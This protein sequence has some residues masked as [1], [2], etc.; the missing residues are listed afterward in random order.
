MKV[1]IGD[2]G[3]DDAV[4]L[5][6]LAAAS[7]D[8]DL[9]VATAGNVGVSAA[10]TVASRLVQAL[11]TGW[12]VQAARASRLLERPQR[13]G[14]DLKVHGDDGLG[15]EVHRLPP[16]PEPADLDDRALA[17]AEVFACG[18][19]TAVAEA[20]EVGQRP[21]RITWMGGGIEAGN[22]TAHAEFNAWCAPE[23]VDTVLVSRIPLTIVPLD[24]TRQVRL[25]RE[26]LA[27]WHGS[28][29][30]GILAAAYEEMIGRGDAVPHDAV[31]A[32]AWLHPGLFGWQ[33]MTLRCETASGPSYGVLAST[34]APDRLPSLVATECDVIDVTER[35]VA[36]VAA[37]R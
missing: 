31:A 25:D 15:G 16:A 22:T 18:P 7:V 28:T 29:V 26:Q 24:V 2:P 14:R 17:G 6:V 32:V 12:E 21:A 33:E 9:V 11:G 3:V 35:I 5:A 19:L 10:S 30:G 20:I 23:A 13:P 8:L 37:L 27:R 34:T 36:A 4:A 1:F